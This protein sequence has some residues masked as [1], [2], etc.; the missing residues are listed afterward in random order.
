MG[1]ITCPIAKCNCLSRS[2]DADA[3]KTQQQESCAAMYYQGNLFQRCT[4]HSC[5]IPSNHSRA[6]QHIGGII[7]THWT[8]SSEEDKQLV[9]GQNVGIHIQSDHIV[10]Q[11]I[12]FLFWKC[13]IFFC[14]Q[15]FHC[16]KADGV[17]IGAMFGGETLYQL[18]AALQLAE[19][20]REGVSTSQ[21]QL[22]CG[23]GEGW[24]VGKY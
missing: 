9:Y 1:Q 19:T 12:A 6:L 20:E 8:S 18:R 14:Q 10:R 17:F 15:I 13:Y 3:K 21:I 7:Y 5:G 22:S 16:L 24:R 4:N 11:M 23:G 2:L